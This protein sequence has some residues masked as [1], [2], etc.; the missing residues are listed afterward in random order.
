MQPA[1]DVLH[2][3]NAVAAARKLTSRNFNCLQL[4]EKNTPTVFL[5]ITRKRIAMYF[6]LILKYTLNNIGFSI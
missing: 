2:I 1:I 3:Y 4:M 6:F 5:I